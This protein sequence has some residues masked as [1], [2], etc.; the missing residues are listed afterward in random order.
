MKERG[1]EWIAQQ[2]L[3]GENRTKSGWFSLPLYIR[4]KKLNFFAL[5]FIFLWCALLLL[6]L[7]LL[8][9]HTGTDSWQVG[10]WILFS[11]W[12]IDAQRFFAGF[13]WR[14]GW[15]QQE[16]MRSWGKRCMF[17][18]TDITWQ[19]LLILFSFHLIP[20]FTHNFSSL[21]SFRV[22]LSAYTFFA[23]VCSS[24]KDMDQNSSPLLSTDTQADGNR[25][26]Q[27]TDT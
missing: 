5:L 9:T 25:Q 22:F 11:L 10:D 7:P 26:T 4:G 20:L 13:W 24:S 18:G 2:F 19:V 17:P 27:T 3:L 14:K 23:N 15:Q 12:H 1:G 6:Q 21:L 8:N 16:K